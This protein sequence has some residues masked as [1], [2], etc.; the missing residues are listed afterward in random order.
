M[1]TIGATYS[2]STP[3]WGGSAL[4]CDACHGDKAGRAYPVYASGGGGM[5]NSHVAHVA[6]NGYACNLCHE[7]TTVSTTITAA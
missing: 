2:F 1:I 4:L 5:E 3:T 6:T 7:S